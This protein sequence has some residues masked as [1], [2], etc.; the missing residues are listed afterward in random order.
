[1]RRPSCARDG[2]GERAIAL[3]AGGDLEPADAARLRQHLGSCLSC[4]RAL[5]AHRSTSVW[6]RT[7]RRPEPGG[8]L[9][10]ELQRRLSSQI[11]QRRPAPWLLAW[12]GRGFNS[13]RPGLQPLLPVAATVL[14]AVGVVGAWLGAERPAPLSGPAPAAAEQLR[15]E[16]QTPDPNVR[17]IWFASSQD[18]GVR[19]AGAP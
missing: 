18:R 10:E 7:H 8:P 4:R 15:I 1:M 14:L 13:W 16:M 12:L 17:I 11:G 19:P 5:E 9:L 3:Y 2:G 6:V